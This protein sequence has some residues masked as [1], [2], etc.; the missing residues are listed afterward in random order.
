MMALEKSEAT[1]IPANKLFGGA[2]AVVV[3]IAMAY[4]MYL[5][6]THVYT[7]DA[8]VAA[9]MILI[10]SKVSGLIE[11][12]AVTE[13]DFLQEQ[14]L[15]LQLDVRE[16]QLKLS[17]LQAQLRATESS[18]AQSKAEIIM[19]ERQTAG[20]LQSAE[21]QLDAAQANLASVTAD[22]NFKANELKRASSMRD[23]NLLSVQDWEMARNSFHLAEQAKNANLAQLASTQAK[24]VEA[25]A[26]RDRLAVLEHA[27]LRLGHDRDRVA[28]RLGQQNVFLED[29]QV[30][31][32]QPG[33][34][35][36]TFVHAGEY[37]MPGQRIALVHNPQEVWIKANIKETELRHL[38][39]GQ[40]V[41]VQVDAYPDKVFSGEVVRI[42]HAATS[43]FALLPSTN[44]SGNFTKVTQRLPVKIAVAQE[45]ELLR[46]GM[47][48]EIAIDIR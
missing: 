25:Q 8:R 13:G 17:E 16:S 10:S 18:I 3:L 36:Q 40:S 20:Q 38:N 21:S 7:D 5:R 11:S 9:D 19:V 29:R 14:S 46:P 47:M 2:L 43:Q 37:L 35:D 15:I 30:L 33:I 28:H 42:G 27:Q 32:K 22:L 45:G 26:A 48:V 1:A 24:L 41:D 34:V 12:V 4:W 23:K 39:V 31:A 6:S 44:P